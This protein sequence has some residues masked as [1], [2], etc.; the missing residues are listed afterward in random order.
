ML[1]PYDVSVAVEKDRDDIWVDIYAAYQNDTILDGHITGIEEHQ[2][3][4]EAQKALALVVIFDTVKGLIPQQESGIHR[5]PKEEDGTPKLVLNKTERAIV[6]SQMIK[7]VGMLEPVK[8][9]AIHREDDIVILSRKDALSHLSEITWPQL[10]EDKIV[11]AKVQGVGKRRVFL[12]IGGIHV[13]MPSEELTWGFIN[14]AHLLVS[15]GQEI[16]VKIVEI[17]QETQTLKVSHRETLPNPWPECTK[18]Y[19]KGNHYMG[20]VTAVIEQAVFV[21]LEPGVDVYCK[22][23]AFERFYPGDNAVVRITGINND[24]RRIWGNL[25]GTKRRF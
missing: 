17:D 25:M 12:N 3:G 7:L 20:K 24:T 1:Q 22:H 15:L 11:T 21:N 23:L 2:I 8:I 6:R 18:R 4:G 16:E 9:T 13:I 10:A 14:N 19:K 5:Y